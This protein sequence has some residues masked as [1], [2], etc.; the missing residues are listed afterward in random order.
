MPL[1]PHDAASAPKVTAGEWIYLGTTPGYVC[2]VNSDGSA[3]VGYYQHRLKA[4]KETAV[5][6]GSAWEFADPMPNGAYLRGTLEAIVK[7]GPPPRY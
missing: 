7:R 4:I 3:E 1:K 2:S 5:W 6:T